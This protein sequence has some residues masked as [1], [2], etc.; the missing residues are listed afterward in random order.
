MAA[1]LVDW[2][3][4]RCEVEL[5]FHALKNGCQVEALQLTPMARLD[6]A[7]ALLIVVAWRIARLMRL[8]RA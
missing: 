5:F 1:H 7:L 3:R 8:G 2:Y 6:R 4:A